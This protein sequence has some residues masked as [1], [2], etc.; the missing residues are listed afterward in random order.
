MRV[1]TNSCDGAHREFS[2][3]A[4]ARPRRLKVETAASLGLP[5]TAIYKVFHCN[6]FCPYY[7]YKFSH[8][9]C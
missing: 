3:S 6:L 9:F 7:I 8:L 5:L 2:A 4:E 1:I